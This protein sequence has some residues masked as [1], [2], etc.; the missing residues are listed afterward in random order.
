MRRAVTTALATTL[1][2]AGALA[3]CGDDEA[4]VAGEGGATTT[5]PAGGP[6][7]DDCVDAAETAAPAE[8]LAAF[9]DNPDVTWSVLDAR[10]G[11][12]GQAL[13]ELEPDPDEVGYPTFTFV[14]GCDG[15]SPERLATYAL[16]GDQ[17]V[18]LATT[19]A[20]SGTTFAPVLE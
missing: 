17:Y 15:G 5:A 12:A 7:V 20:A 19:D 16:D 11:E 9:P 8:A 4:E 18:L 13:V 1:L 6:G 14:F 3:G 2:A 10:P